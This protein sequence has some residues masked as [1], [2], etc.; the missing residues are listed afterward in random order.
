MARHEQALRRAGT[1]GPRS[2][3]GLG[4]RR[5]VAVLA[6][7]L[8]LTPTL[9]ARAD[10]GWQPIGRAHGVEAWSA[11]TAAGLVRIGFR[12]TNGYPVAIRVQR[13][14]IWCGSEVM[15]EGRRI[16][17]PIEPFTVAPAGFHRDP[18]WRRPCGEPSYFVEFRGLTIERR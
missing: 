14:L 3:R 2:R 5:A 10:S 15:G 9:P 6:W 1:L 13:A 8:A 16:E 11:R 7:L 18:A 12:N 17:T 4:H